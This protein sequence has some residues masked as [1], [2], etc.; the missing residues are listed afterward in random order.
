MAEKAP[1]P[2]P[3]PLPA[4]LLPVDDASLRGRKVEEIVT[5]RLGFSF[6]CERVAD[7]T[8]NGEGERGAKKRRVRRKGAGWRA[9]VVCLR[10]EDQRR[11]M[12]CRL[13]SRL[14]EKKVIGLEGPGEIYWN[15][16]PT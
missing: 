14:R 3:P 11:R 5:A 10:T 9:P 1:P 4:M 15:S 12:H 7:K 8:L 13:R 16:R 6:S 2:P